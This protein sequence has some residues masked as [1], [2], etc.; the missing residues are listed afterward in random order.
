MEQSGIIQLCTNVQ[1][2]AKALK[3]KQEAVAKWFVT[4]SFISLYL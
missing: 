4:A 2:L 1:N 3:L